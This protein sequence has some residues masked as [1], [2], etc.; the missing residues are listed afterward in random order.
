MDEN[1]T[2]DDLFCCIGLLRCAQKYLNP[3][4]KKEESESSRQRTI[5]SN[6]YQRG[7]TKQIK[8]AHWF[9]EYAHTRMQQFRRE[10]SGFRAEVRNNPY[11]FARRMVNESTDWKSS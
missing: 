1:W 10:P 6:R 3:S 9:Y 11:P 4:L 2:Q 7:Q 8:V 5:G